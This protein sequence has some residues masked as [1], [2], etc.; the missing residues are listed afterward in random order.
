[1]SRKNKKQTLKPRI[2]IYGFTGCAGDQLI[3]IH[4][5]DQILNLFEA[6]DIRS[7]V[8]ASSN[9]IEN[10]LDVAFVEGSIST[11]EEIEHIKEIRNRAKVVV[12]LGNCAVAGGPQAMFA[13]DGS[14][15]ERLK[16]V[17]G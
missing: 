10:G 15:A 13:R 11:D 4:T 17:Y 2:G 7:F 9:P 6:T 5:E 1:M 14:F 12:A 8:M 16:K 3:I